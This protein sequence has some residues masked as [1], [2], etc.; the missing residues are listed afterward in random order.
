M[1][2][3]TERKD[4]KGLSARYLILVFLMGVAACAVFFS[5]GFLVGYNERPSKTAGTIEE[6]T[7][8]G[9][10][11][12]LVN[13]PRESAAAGTSQTPASPAGELT[14]E[15]IVAPDAPAKA[16][17]ERAAA[18]QPAPPA[19]R[20]ATSAAAAKSPT[21]SGRSGRT[22]QPE[23]GFT[24]Q[25]TASRDKRDAEKLVKELRSRGFDVFVVTP[26]SSDAKDN[27]YR[28]Q[29]GP[30]ATREEAVRVRDRIAKEGFMPFIKH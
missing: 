5:L 10:V 24:V 11:P 2:N 4:E 16:P 26:Q 28:V 6:V 20:P 25:V 7:P 13:P 14:T 21:R 22:A 17:L 23:T 29:V 9:E 1:P 18:T 12:P 3:R 30:Y 19:L 8:T 15:H 27:L